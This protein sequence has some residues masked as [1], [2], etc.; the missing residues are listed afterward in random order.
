MGN[1]CALIALVLNG[2]SCFLC[3]CG[4]FNAG[5]TWEFDRLCAQSKNVL[6]GMPRLFS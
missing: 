2:Y 1:R 3:F 6:G 4:A 5:C